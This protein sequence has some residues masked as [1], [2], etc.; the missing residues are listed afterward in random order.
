[1]QTPEPLAAALGRD[2]LGFLLAKATQRWNELL[3]ERFAAAGHPN[4]RP[5][6]GSV[7]LPL[8]E[9]DGLRM[10]ELARRARLSKQTM[11]TMIRRLAVVLSQIFVDKLGRRQRGPAA[12]LAAHLLESSPERLARVPFGRETTACTGSGDGSV[13]GPNPRPCF[14]EQRVSGA[15]TAC[16]GWNPPSQLTPL[17]YLGGNCELGTGSARLAVGALSMKPITAQLMS[18]PAAPYGAPPGPVIRS[19]RV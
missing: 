11:T 19:G 13:H 6:S 17:A 9:Q 1:M 15:E 14:A 7:L 16:S 5:S 4:V 3:A 18:T 10:G 2:D 8:Y 12:S